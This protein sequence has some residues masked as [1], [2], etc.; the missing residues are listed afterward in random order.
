MKREPSLRDLKGQHQDGA[1]KDS[2]NKTLLEVRQAENDYRN[3]NQHKGNG[4]KK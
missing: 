2:Y 1:R 4:R 3:N